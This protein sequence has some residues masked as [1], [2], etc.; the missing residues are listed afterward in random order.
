MKWGD[1][2]MI[3]TLSNLLDETNKKNV[4]FMAFVMPIPLQDEE[5]RK[6]SVVTKALSERR[7]D[8][9]TKRRE[10]RE[11]TEIETEGGGREQ[12]DGERLPAHTVKA[13]NIR[14]GDKA[15][16]TNIDQI[17]RFSSAGA[18]LSVS[19]R[20]RPTISTLPLIRALLGA[21]RK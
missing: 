19:L 20:D 14:C 5:W 4:T 18:Q 15:P 8:Y 10:Y 11:W 3:L 7:R 1:P 2:V 9:G 16:Q 13:V 21:C 17:R 6:G 12:Q